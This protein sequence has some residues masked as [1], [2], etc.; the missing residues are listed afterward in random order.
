MSEVGKGLQTKGG[1]GSGFAPALAQLV[2]VA[3]TVGSFTLKVPQITKCISASSVAGLSLY[4]AYFELNN[5]L[6][7]AIYHYLQG[8]PLSTWAENLSLVA[9]QTVL[10]AM[11]WKL[12]SPAP[13][14]AHMATFLVAETLYIGGD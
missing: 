6:G 9:Q 2:G 10:I 4:G 8:Y 1:G 7:S 11:L 13:S 5:Y 14:L 12:S 3:V